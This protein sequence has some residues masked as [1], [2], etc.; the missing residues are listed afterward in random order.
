MGAVTRLLPGRGSLEALRRAQ[1]PFLLVLPIMVA[2]SL[3][4][5]RTAAVCVAPAGETPGHEG[6][7]PQQAITV[8]GLPLSLLVAAGVSVAVLAVAWAVMWNRQRRSLPRCTARLFLLLAPRAFAGQ[9]LTERALRNEAT[10]LDAQ[11]LRRLLLGLAL[12]LPFAL[13]CYAV[14]FVLLRVAGRI[15]RLLLTAP[16]PGTFGSP[17]AAP[18]PTASARRP[19]SALALG[20]GERGPPLLLA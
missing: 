15:V 6:L 5:R 7:E 16:P 10:A 1:L 17:T 12:Q 3:L 11:A 2:G 8:A 20:Y 13:A 19:R 9:E 14:A 18:A 4:A